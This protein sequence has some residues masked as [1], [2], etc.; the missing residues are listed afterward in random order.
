MTPED[1]A[2]DILNGLI[3][4]AQ[5]VPTDDLSFVLTVIRGVI[6]KERWECAEAVKRVA[7]DIQTDDE[8]EYKGY[9]AGIVASLA[10]IRA[11]K[12]HSE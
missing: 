8:S 7:N 2:Q 6:A 1:A 12:E 4:R 5:Q 3:P 9:K 10:A 11:R